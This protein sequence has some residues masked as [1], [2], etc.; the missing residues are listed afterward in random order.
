MV[1]HNITVYLLLNTILSFDSQIS[2]V[3]LRN[4][5]IEWE[6]RKQ[7]YS[8]S[9]VAAYKESSDISASSLSEGKA[10]DFRDEIYKFM[11]YKLIVVDVQ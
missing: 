4:E 11:F 9:V 7:N 3:V 10:T 8:F 2:L 6:L 1:I 5:R